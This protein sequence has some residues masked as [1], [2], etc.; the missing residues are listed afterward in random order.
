MGCHELGE[1]L[2]DCSPRLVIMEDDSITQFI[3]P[4]VDLLCVEHQ[5]GALNEK[6]L[7][8]HGFT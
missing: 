7:L 8:G 3:L 6:E 2:Q 1:E 5:D 4:N